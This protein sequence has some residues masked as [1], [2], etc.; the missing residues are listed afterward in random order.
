MFAQVPVESVDE[1]HGCA[2]EQ[3]LTPVSRRADTCREVKVDTYVPFVRQPRLPRMKTHS[4]SDL[5][6]LEG[7]LA[8]ERGGHRISC[9]GECVEECV[10]LSSHLNAAIPLER[11]TEQFSV[12]AEC[13]GIAIAELLQ[14]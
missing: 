1:R 3:N 7:G 9:P 4:T 10:P 14:E 5:A 8:V 11:S 12:H 13:P 6:P 2:G